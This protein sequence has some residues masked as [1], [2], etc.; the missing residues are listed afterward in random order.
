MS[1]RD[2]LEMTVASID[3]FTSDRD[4]DQFHTVK[5]IVASI[6]IEAAELCETVQWS[7]PT[8]GEVK[9]NEKLLSDI[10]DEVA[11]VMTYCLRLCSILDVNP[12]DII[13]QKIQKNSKKYPIGVSKGSSLKYTAYENQ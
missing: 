8:P 5:N 13:Q 6:S 12:I 10:S 9:G 2:S 1:T 3:Q 7:N 11:D 4:W